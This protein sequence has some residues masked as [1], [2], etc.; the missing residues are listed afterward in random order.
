MKKIFFLLGICFIIFAAIGQKLVTEMMYGQIILQTMESGEIILDGKSLGVVK[1]GTRSTIK[2][3]IV[4]KHVLEFTFPNKEKNFYTF[5]LNENETYFIEVKPGASLYKQKLKLGII[6]SRNGLDDNSIN[7]STWSGIKK[8]TTSNKMD[9]GKDFFIVQPRTEKEYSQGISELIDKKVTTII[10]PGYYLESQVLDAAEKHSNVHFIVLDSNIKF[11]NVTS[12]IFSDHE[13]SFIIGIITALICKRDGKDTVGFIGSI[14]HPI[15]ERYFAGY[16][17]GLKTI[18]PN[19]KIIVRYS[20][21]IQDVFQTSLIAKN[22]YSEGAYIIYHVS[23]EAGKGIIEEAIAQNL[24]GYKCWVVGAGVDDY[25]KGIYTNGS[26]VLTS[27]IKKYDFV[28]ESLLQ[29]KANGSLEPGMAYNFSL[30]QEALGIP[31]SNPNLDSEILNIALR[32]ISR[33]K[34]KEILVSEYLP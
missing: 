2:E 30:E 20:N 13:G 19:I 34:K 32:Y 22:I 27:M 14:K 16:T 8:F 29:M 17:Q 25:S 18:D 4:G 24:S 28:V 15:I 9:Q 11:P 1:E 10:A 7:A 12:A 31:D 33:I 5:I 26:V 6:L 21:T 3:V 23:G